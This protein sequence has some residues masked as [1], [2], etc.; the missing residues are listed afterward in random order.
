MLMFIK[1]I[2]SEKL[3]ILGKKNP[4]GVKMK[5]AHFFQM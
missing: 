5:H 2:A 4:K 3:E 1:L